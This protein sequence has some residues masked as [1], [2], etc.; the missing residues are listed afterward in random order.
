M[1]TK[2]SKFALKKL[3]NSYG[4]YVDIEISVEEREEGGILIDFGAYSSTE[5]KESI[6]FGIDYF[7]AHHF[8]LSEKN[9]K[10][11]ILDL[12][13]MVVDT[14]KI[15]VVYATVMCLCDIFKTKIHGLEIDNLGRICF[16]K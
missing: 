9:I 5:W 8:I 1:M 10:V 3:I 13:T 2:K 12:K 11:K 15:V 4:F 16:P 6:N 7:L 14:K